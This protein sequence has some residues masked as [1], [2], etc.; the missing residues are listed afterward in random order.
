LEHAVFEPDGIGDLSALLVG[1]GGTIEEL[2]VG[3]SRDGGGSSVG[4][5]REVADE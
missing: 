1:V 2:I 5:T 4:D 3:A